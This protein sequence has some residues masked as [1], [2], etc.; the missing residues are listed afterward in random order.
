VFVLDA[1][2]LIEA[3]LAA[4]CDQLWVVTCPREQQIERLVRT[5]GLTREE[6]IVRIDA[7]APQAEKVRQADVVIDN[8]GDLAE[9]ERQV[10]AAWERLPRT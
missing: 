5:R 8:G 6:A 2:K 3:G 7:Q 9:T 10:S 4:H 1:I